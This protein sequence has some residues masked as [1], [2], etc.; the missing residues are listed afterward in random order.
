MIV[1][2]FKFPKKSNVHELVAEPFL[3]QVQKGMIPGHSMVFKYGSQYSLP[4]DVQVDVWEF[5]GI[6]T[7]AQIYT[8]LS[9]DGEEL[10]IS[11][12]VDTDDHEISI[13]LNDREE[14]HEFLVPLN[15]QT[16]V[17]IIAPDGETL[18]TAC[19]RIFNNNGTITDG[20]IY[21]ATA[22]DLTAG[23]PDD[24]TTVKGYMGTPTTG[25]YNQQTKQA[26]FTIPRDSW[27]YLLDVIG[28]VARKQA[29]EV[30]MT[31][32]FMGYDQELEANKVFRDQPDIML[33]TAGQSAFT[34][35]AH[36]TPLPPG[37]MFKIT[38]NADT[39]TIG[40]TGIF[41]MLLV[42]GRTVNEP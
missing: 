3:L 11:S 26:I 27:G 24:K 41:N 19:N 33:N 16:P 1:A 28:A 40:C 35:P 6:E 22:G 36:M 30:V 37:S 18:W 12:S 10:F 13:L 42:K 23:V 34:V 31:S 25:R 2:L 32:V 38:A 8:P 29:G 9:E 17:Q 14:S 39:A 4:A 21:V 5:G 15:G 20:N 7:T